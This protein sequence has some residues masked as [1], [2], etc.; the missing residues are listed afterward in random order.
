MSLVTGREYINRIDGLGNEVWIGGERVKG[1][2]SEHPAFKGIL[3]S[4]AAMYDRQVAEPDIF[5]RKVPGSD[6]KIGFS[7]HQPRSKNDLIMRM[8]ATTE[9]ARMNAGM[10]GRP[11]DYINT[12]IMA[13]A[14]NLPFY[15]KYDR[16]LGESISS[17]YKLACLHD[18]TFTH[19]LINPQVN[20]SLSYFEYEE[21][22]IAAK[23]IAETKDGLVLHGARVLATQGG[24][25][26]E[27]LVLP[28]GG[29][30]IDSSYMYGFCIPS[31]TPGMKFICRESFAGTD[32][33]FDYPLSS[34]F[35]EMDSIVVFDHVTI[36]WDRVFLYKHTEQAL[37][38]SSETQ[39]Y[40]MLLFQAVIRQTVKT[41]FML[42]VAEK[43]VRTIDVGD[44]QHIKDKMSEIITSLEIMKSL[45]YSSVE[46][47]RPAAS[48]MYIPAEAPLN[49]AIYYYPRLYPRLAQI[50]QQI[51]AS[52]LIA[53]P[54]SK[55]FTSDIRP[56]LDQYLQAAAASAPE[57]VQSFRLAWDLTMSAFGSRQTLYEQYF[58]GDPIRLSMGL[59][60][61]F[62]LDPYVDRVDIFMKDSS[63]E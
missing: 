47:S 18:L 61:D 44:Y 8:Q 60:N 9:W 12:G 37:K 41:E 35:E 2:L 59:Y 33:G 3:K 5:T 58:F 11:P 55:D 22:P 38:L 20:R 10:M 24:L 34:Q 21:K 53:I 23:V 56:D 39:F 50:I 15:E 29:T 46:Q 42:G 48:G 30:Y 45:L 49:A 32:C 43:L 26:D 28:A 63:I 17:I 1:K 27:I 31:N 13:L 19:T 62:N 14:S 6:D 52:G 57:R 51:G 54:S 7:Y 16:R 25:T 4:K 36:P 40:T